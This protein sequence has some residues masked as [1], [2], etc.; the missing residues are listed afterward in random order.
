MRLLRVVNIWQFPCFEVGPDT[1]FWSSDGA[2]SLWRR[3]QR[4]RWEER[5]ASLQLWETQ[6]LVHGLRG[7]QTAASTYEGWLSGWHFEVLQPTKIFNFS[8]FLTFCFISQNCCLTGW[9]YGWNSSLSLHSKV[10]G[11]V[12]GSGH[13]CAEFACSPRLCVGSP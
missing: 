10:L 11:W 7:F 3:G 4:S 2:F 8:L 6:K 13:F 9:M 1:F 5:A 12:P